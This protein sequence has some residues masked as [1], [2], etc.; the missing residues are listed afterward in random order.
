MTNIWSPDFMQILVSYTRCE[1]VSTD[2]CQ[3]HG[4][5]MLFVFGYTF[6]LPHSSDV[7]L[8]PL[9]WIQ[10]FLGSSVTGRANLTYPSPVL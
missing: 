3:Y 6:R 10:S 2:F 8:V 1:I 4:F 7:F 5:K 9:K